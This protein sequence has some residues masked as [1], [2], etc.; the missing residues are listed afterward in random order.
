MI[1][2]ISVNFKIKILKFINLTN[3]SS[4]RVAQT[5]YCLLNNSNILIIAILNM[6]KN[7]YLQR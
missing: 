2:R 1:F 7:N 6:Q 4:D 3:P 5:K